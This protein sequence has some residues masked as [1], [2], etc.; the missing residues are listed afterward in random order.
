MTIYG[1]GNG[2]PGDFLPLSDSV[3]I[4]SQLQQLREHWRS[5]FQITLTLDVIVMRIMET[6]VVKRMIV[7]ARRKSMIVRRMIMMVCSTNSMLE[8][9]LQN[10]ILLLDFLTS[11]TIFVTSSTRVESFHV[12]TNFFP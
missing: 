3:S 7:I 10:L 9:L 2:I 1:N 4:L 6:M 8:P 12:G 11:G 5:F